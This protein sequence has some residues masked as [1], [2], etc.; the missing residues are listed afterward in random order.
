M[1]SSHDPHLAE[2]KVETFWQCVRERESG[3]K[4]ET[5]STPF[6]AVLSAALTAP[7]AAV[8]ASTATATASDIAAA[9]APSPCA[10]LIVFN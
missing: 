6:G 10:A 1:R 4:G 9:A 5:Q 3:R 7:A 2:S 8:A